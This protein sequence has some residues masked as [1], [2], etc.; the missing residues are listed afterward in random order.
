M[1]ISNIEIN[2]LKRDL[3]KHKLSANYKPLAKDVPSG[4][5]LLLGDE[6]NKIISQL[7]AINSALPKPD[8]RGYSSYNK[9]NNQSGKPKCYKFSKNL[10]T[11]ETPTLPPK[12]TVHRAR[13]IVGRATVTENQFRC[14]L[15]L[16]GSKYTKPFR[17][18]EENNI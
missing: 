10:R 9:C 16:K 12:E 3:V 6:I 1:G 11:S 4:S 8:N 13:A 18:I 5:D 15:L 2:Q 17:I 14:K 7:S